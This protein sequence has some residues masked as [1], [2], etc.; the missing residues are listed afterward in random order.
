MKN[1][2]TS[3]TMQWILDGGADETWDNYISELKAAG[4]DDLLATYQQAYDRYIQ[5][6][7]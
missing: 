3:Y 1:I 5:N 7:E 2:V 6:M 4:L